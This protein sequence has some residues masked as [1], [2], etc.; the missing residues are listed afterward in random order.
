MATYS[1]VCGCRGIL[2]IIARRIIGLKALLTQSS[3]AVTDLT[4]TRRMESN[5]ARTPSQF[6]PVN[7]TPRSQ[8]RIRLD[9]T[10]HA[11]QWGYVKGPGWGK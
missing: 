3:H 9:L 10:A 5:K 4:H 2:I 8:I 7:Q 1:Q 6:E 11:C